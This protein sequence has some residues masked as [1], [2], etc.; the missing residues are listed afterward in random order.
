MMSQAIKNFVKQFSYCPEIKN[1]RKLKKAKSF[2]VI[3]MGGS[4]L[5]A[6]IIKDV[7]PELDLTIHSD[8]GLPK[9]PL[10]KLKQSLI[11]LSSYS[12]NTE[13]VINGFKKALGKK[14]SVI[15]IAMGGKLIK[16]SCQHSVPYIQLPDTGI[17]PRSALGFSFRALTKAIGEG[18]LLKESDL[19]ISILRP[20]ELE[21]TGKQL[22]KRLRGY[23]P[24]IYT[25]SRN[26]SIAYN[27]K[28]KFNETGKIPAFYNVVPELNHNEMS[29]FDII[30]KTRLLS[31][32][33]YFILL[34]DQE[35]NF[36]VIKRMQVLSRLY[37]QRGLKVETLNLTGRSRLQK[38]FTSL[39]IADWTA[40]HAARH[41]G[42]EPDQVSMAEEFKKIIS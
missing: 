19:L 16:L 39:L 26:I 3:G 22:A 20:R 35:D 40:F 21:T 10:E 7:K 33:F 32:Q 38:I 34:R 18:K 9:L 15:S 14:L 23:V 1:S 6:D 41:Y 25:S 4:H 37:Q 42:A 17:Q 5:A 36:R 12:G 31:R 8:Y 13:E 29:G 28:I 11:I 2:I 30:P 27:W 24:I